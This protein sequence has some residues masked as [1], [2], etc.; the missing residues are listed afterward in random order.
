MFVFIII[1][2]IVRHLKSY[3][4][5]EGDSS[6]LAAQSCICTSPFF[7]SLDSYHVSLQCENDKE[8]NNVDHFVPS[9]M[10]CLI[11]WLPGTAIFFFQS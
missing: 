10:V 4:K 9:L 11:N 1:F 5:V 7:Q 2:L 3:P 8:I 6:A